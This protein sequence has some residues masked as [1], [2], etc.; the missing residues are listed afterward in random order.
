MISEGAWDEGCYSPAKA[1]PTDSGTPGSVDAF[2]TVAEVDGGDVNVSKAW[3]KQEPRD[4]SCVLPPS[5]DLLQTKAFDGHATDMV[6]TAAQQVAASRSATIQA[7]CYVIQGAQAAASQAAASKAALNA[8]PKKRGRPPHKEKLLRIGVTE[9]Q[10]KKIEATV[11]V[12]MSPSSVQPASKKAMKATKPA[13]QNAADAHKATPTKIGAKGTPKRVGTTA[14][15]SPESGEKRIAKA[16][17][18]PPAK[19]KRLSKANLKEGATSPVKDSP[20]DLLVFEEDKTI[21]LE[22]CKKAKPEEPLKIFA[23]RKLPPPTDKTAVAVYG[24]KSAQYH[25]MTKWL[26]AEYPEVDAKLIGKSEETRRAYWSFLGPIVKSQLDAITTAAWLGEPLLATPASEADSEDSEAL[27]AER[28]TRK[29][30]LA[31]HMAGA[32]WFAKARW[33]LHKNKAIIVTAY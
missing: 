27:L 19:V 2:S 9:R 7:G 16:T 17:A 20:A 15:R 12:A 14:R 1:E 25:S 33:S 3:C 13:G 24:T 22:M 6:M 29:Q 31:V 18:A 21:A 8:A 10:P 30:L 23:G 26:T 32:M 28:Q 11:P 5:Q 4:T